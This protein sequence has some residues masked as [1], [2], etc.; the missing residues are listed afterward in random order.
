MKVF[1]STFLAI[2]VVVTCATETSPITKVVDLLNN[3]QGKVAAEGETAKRTYDEFADW[4]KDRSAHLKFQ[5][6][7]GKSEVRRLKAVIEQ[8]VALSLQLSEKL[9]DYS[10]SIS[11]DEADLKAA[12]EI[13][14]M[15]AGDFAAEEN[16]FSEMVSALGRAIGVLE[17]E[18]QKGGAS[19]MQMSGADG[20]IGALETLVQASALGTA[21]AAKLTALIQNA[22]GDEED[23]DS[24]GAPSA[25]TYKAHSGGLINTLEDLLEKAQGQLADAR[26]KEKTSIHNFELL[27]QSL[28]DKIKFATKEAAA[29]KTGLAESSEKQAVAKGDLDVTSKDLA[30]DTTVLED[31]THDCITKAEDFEAETQSRAEEMKALAEA[32][33]V[34]VEATGAASSHTYSL[35]EESFLQMRSS[36]SDSREGLKATRLVRELARRHRSAA[37]AQL[38]LRM[39]SA[40]RVNNGDNTDPFAKVTGLIRDMID[41]LE[42]EAGADATQKAY[43]DKEMSETKENKADL[44]A[45]LEKLSTKID[46]MTFRSAKLKEQVAAL[47]NGLAHILKSQAEM[48][49]LRQEEN[50]AYVQNKADLEQGIAGVQVALK[51]LREYYAKDDKAHDAADGSAQGII[52]LLEVVESDFSQGLAE[53]VATEEGSKTAYESETKENAIEK[54]TKDKDIEYKTKESI[55]L[56]KAVSEASSDRSGIK[57]RLDAVLEYLSKINEMCVAQPESYKERTRRTTEEIRGLQTALSIL[58]G[59][60]SLLQRTH[61]RLRRVHTQA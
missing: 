54:A 49:K 12:N 11:T 61:R 4:C 32:K 38:A 29:A 9:N 45:S 19:M 10:G 37:L 1:A 16:E 6:K 13:R 28:Q 47:Q 55:S 24:L 20:V 7:T 51:V 34:V 26:K 59:D 22:Q 53:L 48:D 58:E 60:A 36:A 17:K 39:E 2:A 3:L 14:T 8:Q 35:M 5:I 23:S 44:S 52:G 40:M 56:D 50:V 43:C 25:A 31:V 57:T 33:K 42:D 30:E 27:K 18:M 15:E 41:R 46:T 21:D